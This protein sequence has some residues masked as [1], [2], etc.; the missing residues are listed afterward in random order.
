M[1]ARS[2]SSISCG[3]KLHPTRL[4]DKIGKG[5]RNWLRPLEWN[6]TGRF[7]WLVGFQCEQTLSKTV[8]ETNWSNWANENQMWTK[9]G[10]PIGNDHI[11]PIYRHFFESMIFRIQPVWLGP[12]W[13]APQELGPMDSAPVAGCLSGSYPELSGKA[14]RPILFDKFPGWLSNLSY[15]VIHYELCRHKGCFD[16]CKCT[17]SL[18]SLIP[19]ISW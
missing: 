15:H 8:K 5:W 1:A 12:M 3:K 2:T 9:V 14:E 17:Q 6:T 18:H 7:C 19:W 4:V 13:S 10:N 16:G 11:S